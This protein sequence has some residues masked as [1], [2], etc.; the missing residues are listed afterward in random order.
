MNSKSSKTHSDNKSENPPRRRACAPFTAALHGLTR[1]LVGLASTF[2]VLASPSIGKAADPHST[3]DVEKL[4]SLKL[5]DIL[6][7]NVTSVSKAPEK[8]F[9]AAAAISVITS[10]DIRRSGASSIQ[11]ALRLAPGLS[12]GRIDGNKWAISSRG[13][14]GIYSGMLLVLIDGRSVYQANN[15]GVNWALQDYLLE[16]IDRIEVV[17]GPGGTLWG[18]NAVNGVINIITK[19]AENTQGA[20]VSGGVGT[21]DRGFIEGRLGEKLGDAG[22]LRAYVKH[23]T[24]GYLGNGNDYS[25]MTQ[26]GLRF[27][28]T[29]DVY[30]L[31]LSADAYGKTFGDA[32]LIPNFSTIITPTSPLTLEQ[33]HA[34]GANARAQF[35]RTW[36]EETEFQAQF[37]YDHER[38][39]SPVIS[40]VQN[41]DVY[42]LDAQMRLPIGSRQNVVFGLGYRYLP[43]NLSSNA[44]FQ[45][46]P[47]D[48]NEQL[49]SAFVNDDIKLIE[50]RLKLT[51]GVKVEH[52]DLTGWDAMPDARL[53]WTPTE[54]QTFW[55]AI[56]RAVQVPGHISTD[57]FSPI[58]PYNQLYLG[59]APLYISYRGDTKVVPQ[60]L[61]S[62]ELGYRV[63][64]V[65]TVYLDATVFYND[66]NH[67]TAG[68]PDYTGIT[69]GPVAGTFILPAHATSLGYGDT[70]GLELSAEYRPLESWRLV[71]TYSLLETRLVDSVGNPNRYLM[72]DPQQQVGLRSSIDL[73]G[74]VEFDALAR[75]VDR[76]QGYYVAANGYFGL[77]LR[78]GWRP[79]DYFEISLVGQNLI[80][81][82]HYEYVQ[83]TGVRSEVTQIPRG[84]YLRMTLRF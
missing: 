45:W 72:A 21:Q 60:E 61:L 26:G 33:Y 48:R 62:Y 57:I 24:Q 8:L 76:V 67:L 3:N 28:R 78:L 42:D 22:F 73:P 38:D 63:Q 5:E 14:S 52:H 34:E 65:K 84:G 69:P 9:D 55:G 39:A 15:S 83:D 25:R 4:M 17:R 6:N 10:E 70:Y 16:D 20:F 35:V 11:D 19:S 64:P 77:D 54:N 74:H 31:T 13:F 23:D 59:P 2:L 40:A 30:K 27:D 79:V 82:Q 1:P 68:I 7:R 46:F 29:E 75:Y 12:V 53:A 44:L 56:S 49:F 80:S 71:G 47:N 43:S 51:L 58:I 66:Y 50:D 37:Y 18:A 32:V 36:S 81:A 41:L